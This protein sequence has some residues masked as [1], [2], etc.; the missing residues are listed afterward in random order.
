MHLWDENYPHFLFLLFSIWFFVWYDRKANVQRSHCYSTFSVSRWTLL[1]IYWLRYTRKTFP[2]WIR[3][4]PTTTTT[5][6]MQSDNRSRNWTLLSRQ[7][8]I[9][10]LDTIYRRKAHKQTYRKKK[11]HNVIHSL[12]YPLNFKSW[13]ATFKSKAVQKLN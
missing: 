9:W 1:N 7:K 13:S 10:Y 11:A 6:C 8:F 3:Q 5:T 2:V 12:P 4:S